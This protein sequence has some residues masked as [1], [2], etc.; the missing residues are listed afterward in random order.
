[1]LVEAVGR[2]AREGF[3]VDGQEGRGSA[4]RLAQVHHR[5]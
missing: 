2:M 4:T 1:M 5:E 3:T